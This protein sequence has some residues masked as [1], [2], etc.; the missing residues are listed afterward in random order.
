MARM[1]EPQCFNCDNHWL[2]IDPHIG[3]LTEEA[4]I[5]ALM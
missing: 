3:M 1:D 4:R 2:G 5:Q